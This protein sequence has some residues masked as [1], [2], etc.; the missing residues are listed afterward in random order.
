MGGDENNFVTRVLMFKITII[1]NNSHRKIK[2]TQS[3]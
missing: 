3:Y 1:E 2:T